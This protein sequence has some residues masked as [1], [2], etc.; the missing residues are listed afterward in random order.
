M[1]AIFLRAGARWG[2]LGPAPFDCPLT[3]R[4]RLDPLY[5]RAVACSN[6]TPTARVKSPRAAMRRP[7]ITLGP[8]GRQTVRFAMR[9]F[10]RRCALRVH[11][12]VGTVL[13]VTD[14]SSR[15]SRADDDC[16]PGWVE[17]RL[18]SPRSWPPAVNRPGDL[19]PGVQAGREVRAGPAPWP[20][21]GAKRRR[22]QL[23]WRNRTR[24]HA[25]LVDSQTAR[26]TVVSCATLTGKRVD[27]GEM[28]RPPPPRRLRA[29]RRGAR[30][31]GFDDFLHG[32]VGLR[33]LPMTAPEPRVP[34]IDMGTVRSVRRG[35]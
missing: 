24:A 32:P 28:H 17:P 16:A 22:G 19:G 26:W 29:Y 4:C 25:Q 5:Q 3:I 6:R 34:V 33:E 9:H 8:A 7:A 21:L 20:T 10:L 1:G 15:R 30:D 18:E 27:Q 11:C 13:A 31:A 23:T 12:G 2:H 35:H 14:L